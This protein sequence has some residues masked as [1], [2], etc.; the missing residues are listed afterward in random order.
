MAS[1]LRQRGAVLIVACGRRDAGDDAAG[2]LAG[3]ALMQSLSARARVLL[4]H[5][6]GVDL[7]GEMADVDSVVVVDAA[8]ATEAHPPGTW[9]KIDY[10]SF[11]GTLRGRDGGNTHGFGITETLEL[12][13]QLGELPPSVCIYAIFGDRFQLGGEPSAAIVAAVNDVVV[14]IAD[15]VQNCIGPGACTS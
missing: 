8:R 6:P 9:C 7:I 5:A 4:T 2:I 3:E 12:A 14:S 11:N 13:D 1:E 10:R 15:D